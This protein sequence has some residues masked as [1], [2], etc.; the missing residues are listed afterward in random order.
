MLLLQM[1]PKYDNE[2]NI[3]TWTWRPFGLF[4]KKVT[5]YFHII[6]LLS[7]KGHFKHDRYYH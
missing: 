1:S 3:K 4:M 7:G 6:Y 2:A 5:L